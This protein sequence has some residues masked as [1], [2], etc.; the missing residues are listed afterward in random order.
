MSSHGALHREGHLETAVHVMACVGQK[1]NSRLV[2]D[3]SYPEIDHS[4]FKECDCLEFYRDVQEAIPLNAPEPQS[5]EVDIS[6]FVDSD[7][8]GDKVSHRSRSGFLIYV[9]IALVQWF[10]KKQSAVVTSVFGA[11]FVIMKQDID[12]LGGLRY[13][14]RMMGI[15]ISDPSYIYGDDM[16]VKHNTSRLESVLRKKSNSVCYHAV[17]ESVTMGESVVGNK[18]SK[19]KIA[20]LLTKVLYEHNKRYLVSNIFYDIHDDHLLSSIVKRQNTCR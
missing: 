4:S 3:L 19:E 12:A 15:L 8:A 17:C 1:Y 2:Y 6:M 13:K 10:S 11:E 5:K 16:S 7:H 14:L 18:P 20:D 9:N